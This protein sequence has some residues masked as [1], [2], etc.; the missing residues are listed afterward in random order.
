MKPLTVTM[1]AFGSYADEQTIDFTQLGTS[2]LYLITGETGSG[3]TT[4]FDAISYALYGW[5]SGDARGNHGGYFHSDYADQKAKTSV[6]LTFSVGGDVYRVVRT[7][8]PGFSR[9][10][11][12]LKGYTQEAELTLPDGTVF[13]RER[14]V[15]SRIAQVIGLERGQFAQ[16]VMIAQNDFLRFLQS[17]TDERLKILRRIFGTQSLKQ[18]QE[19]L[20]GL[21]KSE[22]D[23]RDLLLHDFAR[24]GVDVY[25][26]E[27]QF[28]AWEQQIAA[29]QTEL[30]ATDEKLT[31]CDKAKQ[32]LAGEMAVAEGL[33][34]S[35]QDLHNTQENLTAH[36]AKADEMA[37]L[38]HQAQRGE[39]ALRKVKPFA[40]AAEKARRE[41]KT[42]EESLALASHQAEM[43]AT[44]RE[45][46]TNAIAALRPM[47]EAASSFAQLTDAW[48]AAAEKLAAL[49]ALGREQREIIEKKT[50]LTALQAA[51]D[52]AQ[53]ILSELPPVEEAEAALQQLAK[54][55]ETASGKQTALLALQ[56]EEEDIAQKRR[57]LLRRQTDFETRGRAYREA[58]EEYRA[59]EESFLRNQAGIMAQGLEDG[60]PC[61]VCGAATHPAPAILTDTPVTEAALKKAR[62]AKEKAQ[63]KREEAA[64]A[65]GALKATVETLT[66]KFLAGL[67]AYS[68]EA[69][70]DNAAALLAEAIAQTTQSATALAKKKTAA[71]VSL[72]KLKADLQDAAEKRDALAPQCTTL[73][74]EISTRTNRFLSDYAALGEA[75][76]WELAT[77]RLPVLLAGAKT[78]GEELSARK[79]AEEAA[80]HTLKKTWEAATLRGTT[81]DNALTAAQTLVAERQKA[82]QVSRAALLSA[83]TALSGALTAGD[84]AEEAAYLAALVTEEDLAAL[85]RTLADYAKQGEQLARDLARLTSETAGKENPAIEKLQRRA[86]AVSEAY[87]ALLAA[88]DEGNTRLSDTRKKLGELRR[89]AAAFEKAEKSYAAIK[90]L[91]DTA[92]G[93]LDFETYAQMAYF[94]RVLR[95]ANLRLLLMSQNRYTLLRKEESG[96]RRFKTGLEIEVLDSYTGKVRSA[97]SL[98]GGESFMASLSLA[99]GLSDVVQQA[100]GGIHLDAMFIDEG[101]G[102]LDT[103]TLELAVRTLSGMAGVGR[104]V[105]IISHVAELRER[106]DKQI[107]VEKTPAGSRITMVI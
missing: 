53:K 107:R 63:S 52:A 106:I 47:E 46:A 4:I 39:I 15:N 34:K 103:D 55:W 93:K 35:F 101:F 86:R 48:K 98:S 13:T 80:L 71:E 10:T 40:D 42:A 8:K 17:G 77:A 62:E 30:A 7:L 26:R 31:A 59:A 96:D 69:A 90:Q 74:S 5:A 68:P 57:E 25:R 51:W 70:P 91:T 45:A 67:A 87:T 3:K 14:E 97:F 32:T 92:N 6:D 18:F 41:D 16:I 58:D 44:E 89:A 12:E 84:F 83:Q 64:S 11:K 24:Y 20:K 105:G 19:Q 102:S 85:S 95:A 88:R 99:L 65:A 66:A 94:E 29:D 76:D 56:A 28:A 78:I 21:A 1:T 61:P 27:E 38:T 79:T 37:A 81:A 72:R 49:T 100:A 73:E 23:Q 75:A 82:R 54:E 22:S 104:S 33:A 2:G 50:A 36:R 9:E 43:A 60:Q